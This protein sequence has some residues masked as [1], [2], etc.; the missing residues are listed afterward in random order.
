VAAEDRGS[1]RGLEAPEPR[2]VVIVS[3]THCGCRMGLCTGPG[4]LDGGGL[5]APSDLQQKV[6]QFWE[7][8]YSEWVPSVTKGEPYILVING[9]A[10][11][12]NH[13]GSTTQIS[14]NLT[15]QAR[16]AY[17]ALKPLVDSAA[18]YY[19][20]RGT[21]AHVG[22]SGAEEERLARMLGA[23]PDAQGNHA[24]WELWLSLHGHLCHFTHHIGVTGSS[25]YEAT[26][27]GKEMVEAY[28]EAGRWGR[29]PPQVMIRSHRHRYSEFRVYGNRGLHIVSITPGWQLKTPYVFRL[30]AR[31]SEPQLGGVV[32]RVGDEELHT[33]ALVKSMD[34]QP[35][36]VIGVPNV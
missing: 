27:V 6:A 29:T 14:H 21:E 13:H 34:R 11:D 16:I 2:S 10:L 24:R 8:F 33:R 26:A 4:Q 19:H 15:D 7:E 36:E 22:P 1:P 17:E 28:V 30:Q 18:I 5:Y 25:S 23:K 35:V 9:D 31:L 20:V 12:G 32:V 3:D